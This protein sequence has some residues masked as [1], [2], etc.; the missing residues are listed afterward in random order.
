VSSRCCFWVLTLLG[1]LR[2]E[3]F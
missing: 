1:W 2:L 3:K